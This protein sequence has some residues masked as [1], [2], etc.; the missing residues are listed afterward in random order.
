MVVCPVRV[1]GSVWTRVAEAN[2]PKRGFS[3]ARALT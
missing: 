3:G 2:M 1:L